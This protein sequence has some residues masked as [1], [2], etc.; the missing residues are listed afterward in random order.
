MSRLEIPPE[1]FRRVADQISNLAERFLRDLDSLPTYPPGISGAKV[2]QVFSESLPEEGMGAAALDKLPDVLK[3]SRPP[4]R[5]S[6]P[7]W[8]VAA[9]R[10]RVLPTCWSAC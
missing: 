3:W 7:M 9:S 5:A 10:W 1:E 4:V 8:P 2:Q 6:L